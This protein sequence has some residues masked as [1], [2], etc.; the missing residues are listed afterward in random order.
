M[1]KGTLVNI[2]RD[3]VTEP[4]VNICFSI[5]F[6]GAYQGLQNN[7][8][9]LNKNTNVISRKHTRTY[10]AVVLIISLHARR[11]AI[12]PTIKHYSRFVLSLLTSFTVV[13]II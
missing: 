8:L 13:I 4:V 10:A 12:K 2:H 5:I 11:S 7:V 6:R 1:A 3:K 9:N